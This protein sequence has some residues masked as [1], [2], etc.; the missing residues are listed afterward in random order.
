MK[1]TKEEW[2][3]NLR[4]FID[5]DLTRIKMY[6]TVGAFLIRFT[7]IETFLTHNY[8]ESSGSKSLTMRIAASLIGNPNKEGSIQSA[9][10][11]KTGLELYLQTY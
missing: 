4:E 7:P 11:S 1:G 3:T 9:D 5:F 6:A 2:I 10:I 8:F